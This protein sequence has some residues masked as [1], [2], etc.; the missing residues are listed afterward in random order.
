MYKGAE[1]R[2]YRRVQKPFMVRFQVR[3]REAGKVPP[4]W[5][6]GAVLN[7]GAGGALFYYNRKTRID[8]IL[9]LKMNFPAYEGSINCAGR[10]IRVEELPYA[11]MFLVAVVFTDIGDKAKE[12]LNKAVEELH[13]RQGRG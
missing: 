3:P 10:V 2:K 8:S 4:D 11:G 1:R 7:L 6:K 9:D 12:A 5:D 13:S